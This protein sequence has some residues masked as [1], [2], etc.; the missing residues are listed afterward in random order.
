MMIKGT[1]CQIL[2]RIVSLIFML[3]LTACMSMQAKKPEKMPEP[4]LPKSQQEPV[5]ENNGSI[6][7]ENTAVRLF[8][9][10]RARRVGDILLVVLN[11]STNA[12]KSATTTTSKENSV[13][14]SVTNLLRTTA[15][16]GARKLLTNNTDT[17]NK[18]AGAGESAQKNAMTGNIAVT[19][20]RVL[21]NGNLL[22][23]GEKRI[24]INRGIESI[25]LSGIIRQMD[26]STDNTV[27]STRVANA[28][29]KYTG[30]G[31]VANSNVEGWLSRFFNSKW[32]PL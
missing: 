16:S 32:W 13:D 25:Q 1:V 19:V 11:E 5:T 20:E 24:L 21:P 9:D 27:Q 23:R 8:E 4:V 30:K 26:I 12:S 28:Q 17:S 7:Q 10:N 29:I 6:Y 2:V 3:N 15:S 14:S 22:V 18:F 31:Q